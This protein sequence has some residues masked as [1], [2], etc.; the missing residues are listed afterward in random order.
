MGK[1]LFRASALIVLAGVTSCGDGSPM[2]PAR[3]GTTTSGEASAA[4]QGSDAV[5]RPL[6]GR[7]ETTFTF[8]SDG[9]PA[10]AIFEPLPSAFIEIAG[11]CQVSHLGRTQLLAVQQVLFL[12]DD[13]GQP[14]LVDGQPVFRALRNCATLTA[15]NGDQLHHTT[16]GDITAAGPGE[17]TFAGT[18][19]FVGGTGR[20]T[21]ASGAAIFEGSASMVTS[22]G[23]FSMT[24]TLVY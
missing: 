15:A 23:E 16:S 11:E 10:C 18:I 17:V 5:E 8:L 7:C 2:A 20:F 24:G 9:A 19:A 3:V 14:V 13:A 6:S 22:T 4:G 12:L 21:E 1:R